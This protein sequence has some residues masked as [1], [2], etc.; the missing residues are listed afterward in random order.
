M[1]AAAAKANAAGFIERFP[2]GYET[3]L[4]ENGS[5]LSQGQRQLLAIARVIL[6]DP[7]ILVL[8]EATSSIDTRTE[9]YIQAALKTIMQGRTT[10]II[11]HRLNT[12]RDVDLVLEIQD[13]RIAAQQLRRQA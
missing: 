6:A 5:N 8:D 2:L 7:S 12:I 1:A 4:T 11:A 13:G 10:F 3:E 9:G